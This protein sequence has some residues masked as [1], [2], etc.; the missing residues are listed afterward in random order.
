MQYNREPIE[1]NAKQSIYVKMHTENYGSEQLIINGKTYLERTAEYRPNADDV[2]AILSEYA[3]REAFLWNNMRG[4]AVVFKTRQNEK[5]FCWY[6]M[7][8]IQ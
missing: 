5:M 8:K 1:N 4:W 7:E 2:N 3:D 6:E